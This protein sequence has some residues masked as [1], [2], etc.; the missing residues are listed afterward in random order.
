MI[1]R[2]TWKAEVYWWWL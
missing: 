2:S 1:I